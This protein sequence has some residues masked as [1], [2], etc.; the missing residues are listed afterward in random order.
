MKGG[1]VASAKPVSKVI[2]F[3]VAKATGRMTKNPHLALPKERESV[4]TRR[5]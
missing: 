3:G 5:T 2:D 4:R 1:A